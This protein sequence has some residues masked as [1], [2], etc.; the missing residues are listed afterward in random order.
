MKNNQTLFPR[1][2]KVF[3]LFAL[4]DTFFE[5]AEKKGGERMNCQKSHQTDFTVAINNEA[6]TMTG[7]QLN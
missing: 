6:I 5:A 4:E 1:N 2:V 3:L 7:Y